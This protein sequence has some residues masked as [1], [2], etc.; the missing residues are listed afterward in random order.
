MKKILSALLVCTMLT[1]VVV[2][3]FAANVQ[4]DMQIPS[5]V[6]VSENTFMVDVSFLNN[7]TE[8][9]LHKFMLKLGLTENGY[10]DFIQLDTTSSDAPVSPNFLPSN[11]Q[12]GTR[13]VYTT[14]KIPLGVFS[15]IG[16]LNG[17][18]TIADV[19]KILKKQVA[20]QSIPIINY[21]ALAGALIATGAQLAGYNYFQLEIHYYYGITDDGLMGWNY[22]PIYI[23]GSK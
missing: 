3:S 6:Q 10:T 23:I 14:A 18:A 13:F 15:A 19:I 16:L 17:T 7:M 9:D 5:A 8:S 11:P 1:M 4:S 22:G 12:E 2:P 20:I 21:V